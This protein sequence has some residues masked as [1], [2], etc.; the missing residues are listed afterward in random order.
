[1]ECFHSLTPPYLWKQLRPPRVFGNKLP[2]IKP[3]H[4]EVQLRILLKYF[5]TKQEKALPTRLFLTPFV[6]RFL[7]FHEQSNTLNVV[8]LRKKVHRLD[9]LQFIAQL[10]I[11][12]DI[13]RH[14]C[15]ITG[16][17]GDAISSC[18]GTCFDE[19]FGQALAWWV[20]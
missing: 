2:L 18:L 14:G 1:M 6:T 11:E 16:D 7:G 15:D 12:F 17:I 5:P 8:R 20:D 13:T 4:Q 3:S 19:A 10:L 9:F